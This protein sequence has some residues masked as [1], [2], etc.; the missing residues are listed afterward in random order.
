MSDK[1]KLSYEDIK[2]VLLLGRYDLVTK[3]DI[4]GT[5][6]EDIIGVKYLE[7]R[8]QRLTF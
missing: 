2:T 3:E 8:K 6:L 7:R 4:I 1:D 5:P